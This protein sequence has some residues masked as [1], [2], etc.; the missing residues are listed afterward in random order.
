MRT[1]RW[2]SVEHYYDLYAGEDFFASHYKYPEGVSPS[3]H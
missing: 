1:E 3:G 2:E